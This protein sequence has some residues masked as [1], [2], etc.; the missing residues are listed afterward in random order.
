M[1]TVPL[2][3]APELIEKA[4]EKWLQAARK[5]CLSAAMRGVQ[6]IITEIIP[7]RT[8]QPVD[9]GTYRAGWRAYHAPYGA[10]IENIEP[11]API[12]EG[13]ARAG[14]I[15]IGKAMIAALAEWAARK[16]LAA[17]G[18][19]AERVAW[20]IAK[21][22]KRRGIF[23]QGR[24]LEILGE[25]VERYLPQIMQEEISAEIEAAGLSE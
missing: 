6:T 16:G 20:A 15:K 2:K 10:L 19:D 11:H 7:S 12:I 1:T 9:R 18:K 14:N 5:G 8:P 3:L 23:N 25:L 17:K 13:G 22:M 24:G 21:A 4:G